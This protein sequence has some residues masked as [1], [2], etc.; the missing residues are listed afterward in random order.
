MKRIAAGEKY[1]VKIIKLNSNSEFTERLQNG[2][3]FMA[4]CVI[5]PIIINFLVV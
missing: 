3:K 5:I 1:G 2:Y 4:I